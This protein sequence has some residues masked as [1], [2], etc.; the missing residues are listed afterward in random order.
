LSTFLVFC[1]ASD[2]RSYFFHA[3]MHSILLAILPQIAATTAAAN[4]V[5]AV[6]V[7]P[8]AITSALF[9]HIQAPQVIERKSRVWIIP[10]KQHK[11]RNVLLATPFFVCGVAIL[12]VSTNATANATAFV[13]RIVGLRPESHHGMP[14][15]AAGFSL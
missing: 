14:Y 4:A 15:T 10:S 6:T 1:L 9:S 8:A 13:R 2:F 11:R 5:N 3:F 7:G 12:M